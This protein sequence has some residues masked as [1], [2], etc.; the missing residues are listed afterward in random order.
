VVETCTR[1]AE[2]QVHVRIGSQTDTAFLADL[3][4]E[5]GAPDIVIDDGGHQ[6]NHIGITLDFLHPKVA[7]NGVYVV[8]DLQTAYNAHYGGGLRRDGTFIERTKK[9]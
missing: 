8:E 1:Y 2:D 4:A 3:V 7:K 9:P 6:Q 5:F